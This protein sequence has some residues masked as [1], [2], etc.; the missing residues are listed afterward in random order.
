MLPV[1]LLDILSEYDFITQD[2][3]TDSLKDSFIGIR[4]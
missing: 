4:L 3:T 2:L 1:K